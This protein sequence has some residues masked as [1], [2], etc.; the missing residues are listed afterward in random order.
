MQT[1]LE[2]YL[3]DNTDDATCR[4]CYNICEHAAII[5]DKVIIASSKYFDVLIN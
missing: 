3:L 4:T 2:K 5:K 1:L